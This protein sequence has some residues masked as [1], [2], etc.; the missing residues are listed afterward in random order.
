M[1]RLFIAVNLPAALKAA[2]SGFSGELPLARWV[3]PEELHLTLR[4]I[5]EV[6]QDTTTA[7][8]GALSRISF[9]PF[10]LTLRGVGHFPPG[11]RPRVLWVGLDPCTALMQLHLELELALLE[12]GIPAEGRRFSPHLTLARLKETLPAAV[13][14]FEIRHGDLACPPFEVGEFIL[15]SSLLTA[16]GAVHSKEAVY[17]CRQATST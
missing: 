16:K 7:I 4:F 12:T 9:A 15:Y 11:K 3:R 17:S 13:S 10:K 2:F 8:R 6:D 14:A 5:G 1:P